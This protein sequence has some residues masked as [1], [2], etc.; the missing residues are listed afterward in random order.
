[1]SD[2]KGVDAV[3]RA[4]SLLDCFDGHSETLGL[5]ELS[6]RTGFYKS[7]IL[8]LAV[9][10]EKFGYIRRQADG[11]FRLGATV[12]RL[13]SLYR[14]GFNL[15]DIIRPELKILAD[16]IGETASFYVREGESRVCL[17]RS[18]PMRAIRHNVNEGAQ[19]PLTA[20]ASARVL[21]AWSK[22]S[23]ESGT[24]TAIREAGY[25]VSKGERDSEVA[26]VAVPVFW[27]DG[28]IAGAVSV[29]G[30]I[31]R[32]DDAL[33]AKCATAL[34]EA[35]QRLDRGGALVR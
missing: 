5:A 6:K 15:G 24:E 17:F 20:G 2:E 1:M 3:E 14:R 25:A 34:K 28:A 23:P 16:E 32:F 30:L 18:E 8:R 26:A 21:M 29:S 19:F 12:W 10:L 11:Q 9:S 35:V 27:N 7:T 4:L 33:I 22:D 13:G 31:T